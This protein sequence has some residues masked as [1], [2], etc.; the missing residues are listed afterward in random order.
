MRRVPLALFC[1]WVVRCAG[2]QPV[3]FTDATAQAGLAGGYY[4]GSSQVDLAFMMGGGGVGDFDRDGAPDLFVLRGGASPD[5]LYINN[6]DGTFT[7]RAVEWGVALAHV[8]SGVCVGDYNNDGWLDMYVTSVGTP[9]SAPDP[10]AHILYRNNGNGTFTNVASQAGVDFVPGPVDGMGAAFGDYD[11]DGDLDL[12]VTKWSLAV[13][14]NRLFRNNGDGTFTDATPAVVRF[15]DPVI[16]GF[17]PAFADMNGDR[18]PELLIAGDFATSAYFLNV[19]GHSLVQLDRVAIGLVADCNAMGAFVADVDGDGLLDW[20]ISNIEEPGTGY[21]GC[22][23]VLYRNLGNNRFVDIAEGTVLE[24]GHWGWGADAADF[25][26]DGLLDIAETN[27]W[28]G[29]FAQ[30]P[31]A[32]W[33]QEAPGWWLEVGQASGFDDRAMGRGLV[34]LDYDMDGDLDI[35]VFNF[36][37]PLRLFRNELAGVD[38][39]GGAW[40]R[41]LLDSSTRPGLAPDGYGA[42]I[43]LTSGGRTQHR[44]VDGAPTFL[45]VSDLV[46]HIGLGA[47]AVID[48]IVVD[49]P[50]ASRTVLTGVEPGRAVRIAAPGSCAGADI[51][52]DGWPDWGNFDVNAD[53]RIDIDDL[54]EIHRVPTD[55][56]TNG[57]IG[58]EDKPCLEEFVRRGERDDM[59]AGRR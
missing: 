56:T 25:N 2:A 52:G 3:T 38:Q 30:D 48:E 5:S 11:L 23:Q 37:Q 55:V 20:Y 45:S 16:R 41:V 50:D 15:S 8:G 42:R 33:M 4:P 31:T 10:R 58:P 44:Y 14:G 49:W 43:T 6:G 7:D 40:V 46:E 1:A 36:T 9:A 13:N 21:A 27:G 47:A 39:G 57:V 28:V 24:D 59:T 34:T 18:Y 17:T 54:Y 12:F 35:V 51:D 26:N 29:R 22:G 32:L 19:N 53:G